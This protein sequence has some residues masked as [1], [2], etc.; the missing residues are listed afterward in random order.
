MYDRNSHFVEKF[1]SAAQHLHVPPH[2]IVSLKLRGPVPSYDQYQELLHALEHEVGVH[3]VK[4][5]GNLQ[6]QGY[7]LD[8]DGTK[9]IVVEHESGLELL[10]IAGSIASLVGLVLAV[11]QCWG[12]V[13]GYLDRGHARHFHDVE[14]RRIDDSGNV[15]EDHSCGLG[16]PSTFPLSILNKGLLAAARIIDTD[17]CALRDEI[18]LLSERLITVERQLNGKEASSQLTRPK[19]STK[20]TRP[21]AATT[22][23]RAAARKPKSAN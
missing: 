3:W 9:A 2:Q 1:A 13:R 4:V 14:I 17:V 19:R 16:G 10:Y 18:R 5:A 12:A 21:P 20:I 15:Q 8:H 6:G 7:L 22:P 23:S 11:L